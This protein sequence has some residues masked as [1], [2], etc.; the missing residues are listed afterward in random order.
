MLNNLTYTLCIHILV[1]ISVS[2]FFSLTLCCLP[3]VDKPVAANLP[4]T[5]IFLHWCILDNI[6]PDITVIGQYLPMILA[7]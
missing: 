6:R 1:D 7:T 4:V 3:Q 5:Q 2:C